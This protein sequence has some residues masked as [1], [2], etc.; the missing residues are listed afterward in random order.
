MREL[1]REDVPALLRSYV[2]HEAARTRVFVSS[3]NNSPGCWR[4]WL[5]LLRRAGERGAEGAMIQGWRLQEMGS[6][7]ARRPKAQGGRAARAA[8][9][10]RL[11]R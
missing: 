5:A 1:I 7:G 3:P 2:L 10:A 9:R 6:V 8:S 4:R 11:R